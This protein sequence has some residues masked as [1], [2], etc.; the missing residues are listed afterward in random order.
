MTPDHEVC[1]SEITVLSCALGPSDRDTRRNDYQPRR[2]EVYTSSL[3]ERAEAHDA[4]LAADGHHGTFDAM[5][6]DRAD[7]AL[8]ALIPNATSEIGNRQM[9]DYDAIRL[10]EPS[11]DTPKP[12]GEKFEPSRKRQA[13]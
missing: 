8:L 11:G 2:G 4:Y 3:R 1:D 12:E 7:R 6:L 13:K 9:A 5:N 10:S